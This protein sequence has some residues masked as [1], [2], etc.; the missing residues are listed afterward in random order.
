MNKY[1]IGQEVCVVKFEHVNDILEPILHNYG[2]KIDD[3]FI[4]C[5]KYYYYKLRDKTST[6]GELIMEENIFKNEEEA[7]NYI[8]EFKRIQEKYTLK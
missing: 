1:K 6:Y 8:N 5:E 3:I 2:L 7:M 4:K